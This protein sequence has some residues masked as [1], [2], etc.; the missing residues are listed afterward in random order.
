MSDAVIRLDRSRTFSECRG[1]RAPEDPHYRV[2]FWQGQMV[3]KDMILLP[4]DAQGELVPDD[5]KTETW[6]GRDSEAKPVTHYPLYNKPMRDLLE[7]KKKRHA[8]ISAKAEE[9]VEDEDE[10]LADPNKAAEE[11]NF[12]AYL[13]GEAKYEW[14]LLQTAAKKRY[15]RIFQSKKQLVEDLVLDEKVVQLEDVCAELAKFLPPKAA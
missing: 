7:R 2:H 4:F 10:D 15:S 3:G 11:V 13:R 8:A 1:E 9:Q 5:G 6:Q 14:T 12:A